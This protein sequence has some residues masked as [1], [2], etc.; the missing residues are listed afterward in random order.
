MKPVQYTVRLPS[1]LDAVLRRLAEQ[2]GVTIYAM[3]QQSVQAGLA[4][5]TGA[6]APGAVD[7]ELLAEIASVSTHQQDLEQ[8]IDRTL[9]AA[10]AAYCYARSMAMG[11][12]KTDETIKA[13]ID[14][15]YDRQRAMAE[16]RA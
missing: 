12:G 5:Q 2:R 6:P 11:G 13:E 10:C 3:L 9:Y 4:A 16:A 7:R 14:R 15:A 8:M 1:A